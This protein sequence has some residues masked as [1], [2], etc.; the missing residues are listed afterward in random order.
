MRSPRDLLERLVTNRF[1]R[2]RFRFAVRYD[3]SAALDFSTPGGLDVGVRLIHAR[4]EFGDE[5]YPLVHWKS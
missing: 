1:P 2:H 5:F 3:A 4:E